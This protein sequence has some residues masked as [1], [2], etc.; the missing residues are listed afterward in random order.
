MTEQENADEQLRLQD[1]IAEACRDGHTIENIMAVLA[2]VQD[3][4]RYLL[5][6]MGLEVYEELLPSDRKDLN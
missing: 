6:E 2:L 3:K 1:D 4:M 5:E